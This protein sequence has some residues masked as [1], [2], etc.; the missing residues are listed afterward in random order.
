MYMGIDNKNKTSFKLFKNIKKL[1]T[2]VGVA[3]C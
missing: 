1:G 3:P 2:R